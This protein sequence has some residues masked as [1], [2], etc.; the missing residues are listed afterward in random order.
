[1]AFKRA[2]EGLLIPLL[3]SE[4]HTRLTFSPTKL[5]LFEVSLIIVVFLI[6]S[7]SH[8][9]SLAFESSTAIQSSDLSL[10]MPLHLDQTDLDKYVLAVCNNRVAEIEINHSQ[11]LLLLSA[12]TEPT[13]LLLLGKR[14]CPISPLGAVNVRNRFELLCSDYK[15]VELRKA[16]DAIVTASLYSDP[17]VA[18]RGLEYD[19]ETTLSV[20]DPGS[21][22]RTIVF[23][24]IFTMLQFAKVNQSMVKPRELHER[25]SSS[26]ATLPVSIEF[27]E[28]SLWAAVCKDYNPIH[29]SSM[30][31]KAY[32]FPGKI[33]HGNHVVARA[34]EAIAKKSQTSA[35][36]LDEMS[37]PLWMEVSFRRPIVVPAK[38]DFRAMQRLKGTTLAEFEISQNDKVAVNGAIGIL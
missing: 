18:K 33:A 27:H 14:S 38:L 28:P 19:I 36:L 31:A 23:R 10:S 20:S 12:I 21:E 37:M 34:L 7:I 24:Q 5:S 16:K 8:L 29:I 35:S 30:A 11:T 26:V 25:V 17:R 1:M 15:V 4:P 22:G 3:S 9:I 32:G 13:M 6:R 2:F